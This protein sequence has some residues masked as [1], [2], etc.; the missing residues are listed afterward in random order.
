MTDILT[1]MNEV[2]G[3]L[4]YTSFVGDVQGCLQLPKQKIPGKVFNAHQR[5]KMKPP[6]G[7]S[8]SLSFNDDLKTTIVLLS[9]KRNLLILLKIGS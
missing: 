4:R 8:V 9:F 5:T 3:D 1:E 7:V 2:N 6:A